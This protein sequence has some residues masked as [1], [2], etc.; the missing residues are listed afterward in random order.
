MQKLL[1]GGSPCTNWSIAKINR[2]T[3]P[4][5][6]GWDLF[7][8][9]L[10]ALDSFSPDFFLYENNFSISDE[11]KQEIT[12]RL[13]VEPVMVNSALVSA[14]NR[15][16]L[17]WTNVNFTQPQDR[18]IYL[19]S[20]LEETNE[21]ELSDKELIYM[22]RGKRNHF[23]YKYHNEDILP[24][25]HCLTANTHK[26]VPYNVLIRYG[27][28]TRKVVDNHI[29]IQD[30]TFPI[31][32][33]DGVYQFRKMTVTECKRLQTVPDSFIF[34]TSKTQ[35]YKMLGN[36]WTVSVISHIL[37]FM[38]LHE[39]EVLSLF[40]GMS[41]GNIALQELGIK[42]YSYMASEIDK[43]CIETTRINFPFVLNIGDAHEIKS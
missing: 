42:P 28:G 13:G 43:Y 30:S 14:Q 32:L 21:G 35:A 20:I 16:R 12:S 33:K 2:E 36:G 22:L 11:I 38:N 27:R 31:H 17:Y 23:D 8:C 1:L 18:H 25:A 7:C 41:C 6:I 15:K 4:S 24:K 34:P 29:A 10:K 26:G 5:G 9:Y 40:D 39:P 37:S 3:K 19:N